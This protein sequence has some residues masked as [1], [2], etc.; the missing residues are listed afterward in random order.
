[1]SPSLSSA[2]HWRY[3]GRSHGTGRGIEGAGC[4]SLLWLYR[5]DTVVTEALIKESSA[6][7]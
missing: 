6:G 5:A 3:A 1:M 2:A 4:K 7:R